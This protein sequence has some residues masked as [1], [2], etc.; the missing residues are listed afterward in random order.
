MSG[1]WHALTHQPGFEVEHLLLLTDGTV[2]C[3]GGGARWVRFSPDQYGEYVN[4]TWSSVDV[5]H[6]ARRGFSATV[7]ADG[8]VLVAF[9]RTYDPS[10]RT[11]GD[12]GDMTIELFDPTAPSTRQWA[13]QSASP[14]WDEE[15]IGNTYLCILADGRR[16]LIGTA[17]GV[18]RVRYGHPSTLYDVATNRWRLVDLGEGRICN[19]QTWALLP[20]GSVLTADCMPN[21]RY[22][23]DTGRGRWVAAGHGTY[24]DVLIPPIERA[25][26]LLPGGQVWVASGIGGETMLYTP[27]IRWEDTGSWARGPRFPRESGTRVGPYWTQFTACLLPC[28]IVLCAGLEDS[29][30]KLFEFDPLVGGEAAITRTF[31]PELERPT[32]ARILMLLLP[33]GEVLTAF[34]LQMQL[35]TPSSSR[36][37]Q[38]GWRPRLT[39]LIPGRRLTRGREATATGVLFNGMSQATC[40]SSWTNAGAATNYPIVRLRYNES[41]RV[42]YCRTYGHTGMGVATGDTPQQTHFIIPRE[43]PDGEAELCVIANGIASECLPVTIGP[44]LYDPILIYREVYQLIGSLVDGPLI[45]FG[46]RGPEPVPP[47]GPGIDEAEFRKRTL[48]AYE[49]ILLGLLALSA[50]GRSQEEQH[51]WMIEEASDKHLTAVHGIEYGLAMLRKL[52]DQLEDSRKAEIALNQTP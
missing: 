33:T 12:R 17:S 42:W 21:F 41:G 38:P 5:M 19:Q 46:P 52:G 16:V 24:E 40:H 49:Y 8:R 32:V 11:H 7:L 3:H 39:F 26:L 15:S 9:G 14:G 23:P 37:P 31:Q 13:L 44:Q 45:V 29:V 50:L 30:A 27:P 34:G 47:F 51:E 25:G 6:H 10:G 1:T 20:D 4:G 43:A 18:A 35:Y 22:L 28:G 2:L 48:Q 36:D